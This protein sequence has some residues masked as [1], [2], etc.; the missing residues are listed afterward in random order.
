MKFTLRHYYDFKGSRSLA[1]GSLQSAQ[2]WD[3]L[4]SD[5]GLE[6]SAAFYMPENRE[7]WVQSTRQATEI[8]AQAESLASLVTREGFSSL[9]SCGVGRAFLEYHLKQLLPRLAL[10][11]TEFSPQVAARLRRVFPECDRIECHDFTRAG[12][13]P[14]GDHTL[15]LLNRVDTELADEQWPGVFANLAAEN[16]QHVL[17]VATTFLT[18]RVFASELKRHVLSRVR[19]QPLTFA[20]YIRTKAAFR[21]LWRHH[22][23]VVGEVAVGGLTGFRLTRADRPR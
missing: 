5:Q 19:R 15:Y 11:C 12:W 2:A 14:P 3:E 9:V 4:R 20:G 6:Q 8:A 23:R 10:T 17:V 16:V 18:P 22:Y 7:E 13:P 21:D 1:G